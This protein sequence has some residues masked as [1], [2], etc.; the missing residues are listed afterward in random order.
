[1]RSQACSIEEFQRVTAT[2]TQ[3]RCGAAT[4]EDITRKICYFENLMLSSVL[5]EPDTVWSGLDTTTCKFCLCPYA[6][7]KNA[8][9]SFHD[10]ACALG[11]VDT[12]LL[13]ASSNPIP[14]HLGV[15][16]QR[17]RVGDDRKRWRRKEMELMSCH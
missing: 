10:C 7:H 1:M 9:C 11:V 5:H 16:K 12:S 6:C 17:K 3:I 14:A 2:A 15:P 8:S 13:A 4:D